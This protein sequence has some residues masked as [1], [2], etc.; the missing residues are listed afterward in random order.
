MTER[1]FWFSPTFWMVTES[2]AFL[3]VVAYLWGFQ[4]KM[5]FLEFRYIAYV[6]FAQESGFVFSAQARV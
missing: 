2:I 4:T 6:F 5:A 3:L 1:K